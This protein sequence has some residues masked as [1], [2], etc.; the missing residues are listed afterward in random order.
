MR[1]TLEHEWRNCTE[2]NQLQSRFEV[3]YLYKIHKYGQEDYFLAGF[4]LSS[5]EVSFPQR[6]TFKK[7]RIR[8]QA[9][10]VF[11]KSVVLNRDSHGENLNYHFFPLYSYS[12]VKSLLSTFA[13][14]F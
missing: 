1:N 5:R 14:G 13:G 7:V 12:L 4:S 8:R 10:L 11:A 3:K 2:F 6:E 9:T